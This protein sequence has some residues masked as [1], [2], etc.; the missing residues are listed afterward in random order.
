[1][2]DSTIRFRSNWSFSA[3]TQKE[4][5][6]WFRYLSSAQIYRMTCSSSSHRHMAFFDSNDFRKTSVTSSMYRFADIFTRNF[7]V[8][9]VQPEYSKR[10][11]KEGGGGSRDFRRLMKYSLLL[12]LGSSRPGQ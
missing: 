10:A 3:A 7:T 5:V 6:E 12:E 4:L 11:G 1:M 8:H 9:L 2:K